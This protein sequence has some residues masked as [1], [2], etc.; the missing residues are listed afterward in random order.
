M[1]RLVSEVTETRGVYPMMMESPLPKRLP[2]SI[3]LFSLSKREDAGGSMPILDS[4]VKQRI[5][6]R[7]LSGP[8]KSSGPEPN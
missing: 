6:S 2:E 7:E 1:T 4:I 5:T 3:Y 8:S